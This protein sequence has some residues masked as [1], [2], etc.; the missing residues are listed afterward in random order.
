MKKNKHPTKKTKSSENNLNAVKE[1]KRLL[2]LAE[3]K[4]ICGWEGKRDEL[5]VIPMNKSQ[6]KK[7][8]ITGD[9]L[10]C[11]PKCGSTLENQI[12]YNTID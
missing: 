2:K 11:C 6:I 3:F 8:I 1:I 10:L 12:D 9:V 5:N 4:C 7:R